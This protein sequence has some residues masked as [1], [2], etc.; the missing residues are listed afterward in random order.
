MRTL[1]EE[2]IEAYVASQGKECPWCK[3]RNIEETG[4]LDMTD[5]WTSNEMKCLECKAL[6]HALY[7][8]I[9]VIYEPDE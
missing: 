6:W 9:H 7:V 1:S 8:L 3:S 2:E 4:F 5:Q